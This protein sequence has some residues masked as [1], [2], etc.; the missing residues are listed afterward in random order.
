MITRKLSVDLYEKVSIHQD[1]L[2]AIRT[3]LHNRNPNSKGLAP[4]DKAIEALDV[5]TDVFYDEGMLGVPPGVSD[6]RTFE[7][8][9][10]CTGVEC[11]T[12]RTPRTANL[13]A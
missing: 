11:G 1:A 5:A 2:L 10:D 6:A 3:F 8:A 4:L 7:Q 12:R 13:N 9:C